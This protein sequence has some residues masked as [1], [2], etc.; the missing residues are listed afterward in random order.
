MAAKGALSSL[1]PSSETIE[2]KLTNPVTLTSAMGPQSQA[3]VLESLSNSLRKVI[4]QDSKAALSKLSPS[5]M[6]DYT[7]VSPLFDQIKQGLATEGVL[8]GPAQ[9]TAVDS[10]GTFE[11]SLNTIAAKNNGY[12][13]D[14]T[15]AQIIRNIDD[16]TNWTDQAQKVTNGALKQLRHG[17]DT[18]L[19]ATNSTYE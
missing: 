7:E 9:Q 4:G 3:D 5:S 19:K 8:V 2:T 6:T 13:P 15:L 12:I 1:G 16:N 10:L 14:T 11:K 18:M 17:L